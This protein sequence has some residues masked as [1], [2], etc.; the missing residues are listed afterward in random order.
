MEKKY[1]DNWIHDR[2][3]SNINDDTLKIKEEYEKYLSIYPKDYIANLSYCNALVTLGE[4]EEAKKVIEYVELFAYNDLGFL[5]NKKNKEFLVKDLAFCK[6]K[7]LVHEERYQELYDFC[8]KNADELDSLNIT[9]VIYYCKKK[10]G[11]LEREFRENKPYLIRQIIRYNYNDFWCH[12]RKHRMEYV[13]DSDTAGLS[14]FNEGFPIELVI[15]EVRKHI[16]NNPGLFVGFVDDKYTFRYDG[17]GRLNNKVVSYF[18]VI[19][20]H[21]TDDLIT[22]YP[23]SDKPINYIDLNYVADMVKHDDNKIKRLSRT[24]KFNQRYMKKEV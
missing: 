16:A 20:F 12:I 23:I 6:I 17:C 22:I 14:V 19:T 18:T 21:G 1:F 11:Y 5:K 13:F 2:L 24:D 3:N 15:E 4:I 8:I 9:Q 7:L 10:M